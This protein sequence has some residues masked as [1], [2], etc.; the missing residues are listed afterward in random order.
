ME[1]Q[2][3]SE[4]TTNK[5]MAPWLQTS[6]GKDHWPLDPTWEK[7][8]VEEIARVLSRISRYGG[9]YKAE[10]DFYSVAQHSA[11][12]LLILEKMSVHAVPITKATKLAALFHDA[13][14]AYTGFGDVISGFK[15]FAPKVKELE[16]LQ[17]IE[18]AKLIRIDVKEFSHSSVR[19]ADLCALATEA[20]DLMTPPPKPWIELPKPSDIRITGVGPRRAEAIFLES[21]ERIR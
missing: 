13:H 12:V 21:Y 10:V 15:R 16:K 9:H 11:F 7:M 8:S 20:R 14:E 17:D 2:D 5:Q 6:E 3:Y 18:V 1:Q 4:E 19:W